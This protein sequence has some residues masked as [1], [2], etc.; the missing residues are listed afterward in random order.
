MNLINL[1]K[2]FVFIITF[3]L[4]NV[5][6]TVTPDYEGLFKSSIASKKLSYNKFGLVLMK[7]TGP[8]TWVKVLGSKEKEP[9]IPA[10]LS[11]IIT[12]VGLFETYGINERI[13]TK[14]YA[15]TKPHNGVIKGN[16]YIKGMGDP[17]LVTE[18]LWLLMNELSLWGIKTITGNVI[19]D[20]TVFDQQMMDAGRREWNQRAY[21]AY[22]TGL[23]V[24][25]NSV[26]VRFLD[27]QGLLAVTDPLNPYFD[28]RVKK[29]FNKASAVEVR[30]YSSKE[31]LSVFYGKDALD[32][33]KSIYRR[34]ANPRN[35]FQS[36]V[37]NLLRAQN[38]T[39]Q[40]KHLWASTPQNIFELG[41]VESPSMS[42]II[43]M[44][45]KHSNNFI[46]DSLVKVT[47]HK[48]RGVSGVY[49][50]GLKQLIVSLSKVYSFKN[51]WNFESA[52]GLS[53]KNKVSAEDLSE[54]LKSVSER[55]YYPEFLVS[56]PIS[57]MDGTLQDRICKRP[58]Q[59]R[60]KTGLL[61]G[62]STLAGYMRSKDGNDYLFTFMYNGK[63]GDQFSARQTFD[64]FLEK[65]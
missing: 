32:K 6:H 46:A 23:P 5:G 22:I 44:M 27:S 64:N 53:R 11:K 1:S 15:D 41:K 12:S 49:D 26:R 31:V 61:A 24:N 50:S 35:A 56:L 7:K 28:L 20:D 13:I 65:L 54:L 43:K 59:V 18:R 29:N 16:L 2:F 39:I 36:Q 34:V 48:V 19:L 25:W 30:G 47:D 21:N 52:S 62:V 51:P 57:C 9:M 55:S 63:N 4:G 37:L 8:G 45:M 3:S 60:A 10:S 14:L 38:I 40:G 58:G 42:R 33:Q 17:T